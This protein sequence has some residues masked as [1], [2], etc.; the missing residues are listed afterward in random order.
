MK[1]TQG[2]IIALCL[3]AASILAIAHLAIEPVFSQ[4]FVTVTSFATY[5]SP[6]FS[7][8]T[9]FLTYIVTVVSSSSFLTYYS[10]VF[11][12][13]T[14]IMTYVDV[15]FSTTTT[16]ITYPSPTFTGA[17]YSVTPLVG[18]L[19]DVLYALIIALIAFRA[20]TVYAKTL[21]HARRHFGYSKRQ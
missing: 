17:P 19:S 16:S 3:I 6:V 5:V 9:S 1:H 20:K 15:A 11:S 18:Y 8:S 12:T 7:T 13:T 4:T 2:H 14:S 10:T 21:R